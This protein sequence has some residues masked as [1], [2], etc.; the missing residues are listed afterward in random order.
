MNERELVAAARRGELPAFNQP[1]LRYQ[2]LA[3]NVAY[4][5]VGDADAAADATQEAFLKAYKSLPGYRGGSFKAWLLRIV[6][7]TCYDVLRARQRRRTTSLDE[8]TATAPEHSRQ[9]VNGSEGPEERAL[10]Q[11]LNQVIQA[12]IATLPPDQRIAVVL[13][14]VQGLSYQEI[15]DVMGCSLAR[16]NL[17]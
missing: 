5:L 10:R 15:A 14:D 11:E 12:G 13:C 17:A 1:I 4:R 7:N 6:T 16:S 3:Y 8:L 9:M 2:G